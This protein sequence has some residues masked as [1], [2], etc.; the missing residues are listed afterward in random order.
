MRRSLALVVALGL[1]VAACG[2]TAS[3][4]DPTTTSGSVDTTTTVA[5][6]TTTTES[7]TTSTLPGEPI[8][9]G[10]RAGDELM[11]VGV[12][13]DDV[14][15]LR[16]APGTDQEILAGLEPTEIGIVALGATRQLTRSFWIE[17]EAAD[18][19][20]W[21]SLGFVAFEGVTDDA[22]AATI[23]ELGERPT[24]PTMSEL[25]R[26]VAEAWASD[27]PASDIVKVVDESVGDLGEV[28]HDV[29]GLGD[30]AVA[31][32]RL[33]V[34]GEP[35]AGGFSLRTVERTT[36]CG[37]GVDADGLCT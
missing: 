19:T 28:T 18:T 2:G 30:D 34:F 27:E 4:D 13:H 9:F 7:P 11:V 5:P 1:L 36:L 33:H 25:G 26:L 3:P 15:N 23:D 8:D 6:E 35:V 24:A 21:V 17:V 22:T 20:G 29:I 16:A 31:G 32:F 14:L 37:R 10:P 12:A